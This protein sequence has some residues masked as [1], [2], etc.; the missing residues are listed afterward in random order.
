MQGHG[1]TIVPLQ[2]GPYGSMFV[3]FR[4]AIPQTQNGRGTSNDKSYKSVSVIK[5]PW[6][7]S[8]DSTV[9]LASPL[10]LA[11]LVSWTKHK[12]KS[13]HNY[14][15]KGVYAT[16]FDF[17]SVKKADRY[18]I[19]LNN[20]QDVGVAKVTLNNKELGIVWT[21]PFRLEITHALLKKGNKLEVEV[22][23][24]WR[25]RLIGDRALAKEKRLTQT[26]ITIKPEWELLEAGL[27]G[28]VEISVEVNKN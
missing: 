18:F 27:L 23:N 26:N 13:L 21:P 6:K 11:T 14:S 17:P 24:S 2:F 16:T 12:E 4:K 22:I 8:V 7:L 25:N 20:V 5:G 1:K 9:G 10:E 19:T 15:G 28:P 3:I